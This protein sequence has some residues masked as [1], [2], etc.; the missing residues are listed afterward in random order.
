MSRIIATGIYLPGQAV[1]NQQFVERYNL[2]SSDEW[3]VQRTGIKQRYMAKESQSVADIATCAVQN[4]LQQVNAK[5][6]SQIKNIVVATMSAKSATP[7]VAC[8]VQANIQAANAW[9][10]DLN[11]A[12]SGF[13]MALETANQ[14]SRTQSEGYTLVIGAEKMSQVLN[15]NDRSTSVLF[16]DGAG[17]VLIEHDG[18]P[19]TNYSSELHTQFEGN[20]AIQIVENEHNEAQLVMQGRDVFNFVNRTVISSLQAFIEQHKIEHFDYLMC[21]QANQRLLDLFSKRLNLP[22]EKVLSNIAYVANTSAASIPILL[23][24]AIE[25]KQISLSGNQVLLFSGFGG[26]LSWGHIVVTV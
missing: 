7:S 15:L 1:S 26:G 19:L 8:Q 18:Q 17:C 5:V 24:E 22:K 20:C 12:C 10:F 4:M 16:G 6:I 11:G 2:D 3:I 9:A 23:H 21:H 25:S 14:L 13:V